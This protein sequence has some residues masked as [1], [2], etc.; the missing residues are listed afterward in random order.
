MRVIFLGQVLGCVYTICLYG[1]IE[2]SSTFPSGSP[3]RLS[4]VSPY[5]PSVLICSIRLLCD[6][7]FRLI[8]IIIIIIIIV[9][10]VVVVVVR[11]EHSHQH[12][13]MFFH[14]SLSDSKSLRVARI[15]LA[16]LNNHVVLIIF[17][18]LLFPSLPVPL[19]ILSG[20]YRPQQ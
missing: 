1:R 4:R 18:F 3:F 14:G 7:S 5:T 6:W 10:V 2:I 8:I 13:I 19:L 15:L 9:V 16:D 12:Q 20:L 11:W 17:I